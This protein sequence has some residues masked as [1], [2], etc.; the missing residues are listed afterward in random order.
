MEHRVIAY[1][2]IQGLSHH[3]NNNKC[4][5]SEL[6]DQMEMLVIGWSSPE[7]RTPNNSGGS[8]VCPEITV[9]SDSIVISMSV[10][11][12]ISSSFGIVSSVVIEVITYCMARCFLVRGA[13]A[14]GDEVVHKGN[15]ILG[16][17]Y[18][19]AVEGEKNIAYTPRGILCSSLVKKL[20]QN[21]FYDNTTKSRHSYQPLQDS[22][23]S[24]C[25]AWQKYF[26]TSFFSANGNQ[27]NRSLNLEKVLRKIEHIL[28]KYAKRDQKIFAKW[29]WTAN[30]LNQALEVGC[31]PEECR[32]IKLPHL[33][34]KNHSTASS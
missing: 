26:W 22:D 1:L 29:Y 10:Q 19:E 7:K 5:F 4:K 9:F 20:T 3:I 2:D 28:K 16:K 18:I 25:V 31:S 6:K 24:F 23:G 21:E 14:Y 30:H 27:F 11:E 33:L 15:L 8:L 34:I 17:A 12:N 32:K 13:V